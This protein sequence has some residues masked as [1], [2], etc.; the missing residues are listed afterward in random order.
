MKIES[1]DIIYYYDY[2]VKTTKELEKLGAEK[3]IRNGCK[4]VNCFRITEILFTI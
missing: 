2:F 3:Y 4:E 1:K